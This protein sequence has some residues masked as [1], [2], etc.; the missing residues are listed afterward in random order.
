MSSPPPFIRAELTPALSRPNSK[1]PPVRVLV[2][3]VYRAVLTSFYVYRRL[4]QATLP[5]SRLVSGYS[6]EFGLS[7]AKRCEALDEA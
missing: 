3:L 7:S 1:T 2:I 5:H 6:G 4:W